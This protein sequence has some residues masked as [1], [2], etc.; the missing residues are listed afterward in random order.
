MNWTKILPIILVL[1]CASCNARAEDDE[2]TPVQ[3]TIYWTK[4]IDANLK[5]TVGDF[6]S[7]VP[8]LY[9]GSEYTSQNGN[10]Q[11]IDY[12][13]IKVKFSDSKYTTSY[14][15]TAY[16]T[17]LLNKGFTFESNTQGVSTCYKSVSFEYSLV[18][19]YSV[20]TS[21]RKAL[22]EMY[23]YLVKDKS[24]NWPT[25]EVKEV[26]GQDIPHY[27]DAS[28]YTGSVTDYYGDLIF[29]VDCYQAGSEACDKYYNILKDNGYIVRY[30]NSVYNAVHNTKLI[31]ISFMY[32]EDYDV[33]AI[34]GYK[35]DKASVWP[36]DDLLD[37]FDLSLPIY[38]DD[39]ITYSS[40][41]MS[42][43]SDLAG[44]VTEVYTI[45]CAY[46]PRS[47]L[48]AYDLALKDANWTEIDLDTLLVEMPSSFEWPLFMGGEDYSKIYKLVDG[49]TTHYIECRY[50]TLED[51]YQEY[52]YSDS[53]SYPE[54]V[55]MIYR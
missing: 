4:S 11:G 48:M 49:G 40:G 46:A 20:S 45:D 51:E 35:A 32:D 14:V 3:E 39:A 10:S 30:Y 9:Y 33:L 19:Q 50:Y 21:V 29:E 54:F 22:F 26:L 47:C 42:F 38:Q 31:N 1:T 8:V 28:Y 43:S 52:W 15:S 41:F 53:L 16:K 2:E 37:L 24:S 23:A 55:I 34:V 36:E 18:I 17:T 27:E 6:I 13:Y 5:E 25:D 7:E 44:G 12:T